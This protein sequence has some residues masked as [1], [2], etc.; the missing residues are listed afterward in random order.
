MEKIRC[1]HALCFVGNKETGKVL[2]T[3]IDKCEVLDAVI[4]DHVCDVFEKM[5]E[6][7]PVVAV[8]EDAPGKVN[9]IELVQKI[10]RSTD[11]HNIE[12][13]ILLV[14]SYATARRAIEGSE[15]GA[16]QILTAPFT[17]AKLWECFEQTLN[18]TRKFVVNE[19]YVGPERRGISDKKRGNGRAGFTGMGRRRKDR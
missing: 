4:I 3:L 16:N 8:I 18:D 14:L 9:G 7:N 17:S 13:P 2:Q 1:A 6:I 5:N 12:I 15:S 10:R 19:D 11:C